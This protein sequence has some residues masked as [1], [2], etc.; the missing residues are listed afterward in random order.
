MSSE[1]TE[2]ATPKRRAEA[3]G[4]G[5]VAKSAEVGNLFA[6]AGGF[7]IIWLTASRMLHSFEGSMRTMFQRL[8]SPDL[9]SGGLSTALS[10]AMTTFLTLTV[11]VFAVAAGMAVAASVLQNKPGLRLT[12]LKPD[13]KRLNPMGGVKKLFSPH[14]LVELGKNL[15]KLAAVGGIAALT[16]YPRLHDLVALGN[17]APTVA[18]GRVGSLV[19]SLAWRIIGVL[20]TLAIADVAW[21]RYSHEKSMR[22]SKDEV[23]Q[24]AKQQDMPAEVKGKIKQKQR[25]MSRARMLSDVKH[26]D[27]V[28]TN[29]THFAVA[30]RYR[31]DEGAPRVLAKGTDLLALRIRELAGEHEIAIVENKPLARLL[32]AQAEV[33]DYIPADAFGAVAE[34][35]A[36]VWRTSRN[37]RRKFAWA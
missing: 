24:E 20:V 8:A 37:S 4:K 22:M 14:S 12:A 27:V 13:V 36:F 15:L 7:L 25:Q 29:P 17:V 23:K 32:Y 30:L 28:V 5:Q 35:L 31:P 3:R 10:D 9:A 19:M 34:V 16:I 11:P 18:M 33:G 26:A 6:L 1:R 2:K 21:S